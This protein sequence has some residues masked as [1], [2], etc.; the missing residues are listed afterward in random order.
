M[1]TQADEPVGHLMWTAIF[2]T[3]LFAAARGH[4]PYDFRFR[5]IL[6]YAVV[7]LLHAL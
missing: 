6:T 1:S 5:I 7:S 4:N 3:V 2:G